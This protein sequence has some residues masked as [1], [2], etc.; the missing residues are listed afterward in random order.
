MEEEIKRI[1]VFVDGVSLN[2]LKDNTTRLT[3]RSRL[4][5]ELIYDQIAKEK[6]AL[7]A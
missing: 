6:A 7:D 2:W 1:H 4:I 3:N 5:R